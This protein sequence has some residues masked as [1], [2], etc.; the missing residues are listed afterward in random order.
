M[1]RIPFAESWNPDELAAVSVTLQARKA[2]AVRGSRVNFAQA[3]AG[4]EPNTMVRRGYMRVALTA[5]I[6]ILAWAVEDTLRLVL[7][8]S[9]Q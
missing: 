5:R 3:P 2:S 4:D 7:D 9:M 8:A 1:Q 6:L